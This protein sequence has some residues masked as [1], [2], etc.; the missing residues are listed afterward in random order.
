V[1]KQHAVTLDAT[2]ERARVAETLLRSAGRLIMG[3]NEREIVLGICQTLTQISP[4]IVVAWTWFGPKDTATIAPQVCAGIGAEYARR[5]VIHRNLLT[6]RGPAFRA[7]EGERSS[8]FKVSPMSPFGPWRQ[9]AL[10]HGVRSALALPLPSTLE[11]TG[12]IF[13]LYADVAD[14]FEAV[15]VGLFEA[16]A[17]LLGS[18]LTLAGERQELEHAAYHDALTG[19]LNRHAAPMIGRR[20]RR[21]T[22]FAPPA[23]VVLLDLDHFKQLNDTHG[24]AAGDAV[25]VA[26]AGSLRKTLRKGDEALRWGGEEFLVTLP[27]SGRADAVRVADKLRCAIAAIDGATPVTC[28]LGVAELA[29]NEPLTDAV[30]RA[31]GALYRAKSEGR[32]RVAAAD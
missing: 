1:F 25:L 13:V 11:H 26:C 21:E 32:N 15:G 28:S 5:L 8:P 3:H 16:V 22:G 14:Y 31:D 2:A 29:L 30:A 19:L 20:L 4:R 17:E 10:E 12:G 24:H 7:L 23:S 18:V 27:G 6:E 9:A